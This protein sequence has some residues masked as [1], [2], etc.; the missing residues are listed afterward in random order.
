MIPGVVVKRWPIGPMRFHFALVL[1]SAEIAEQPCPPYGRVLKVVFRA[2]DR[3]QPLGPWSLL[4]MSEPVP[5]YL[6]EDML[7]GFVRHVLGTMLQHEIDE[8]LRM[9]DG[10]RPFDPHRHERIPIT[11]VDPETG[12]VAV[13]GEARASVH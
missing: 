8:C 12:T 2:P 4:T 3:D 1:V 10:S 6:P 5:E 13:V 11:S 9:E 7:P